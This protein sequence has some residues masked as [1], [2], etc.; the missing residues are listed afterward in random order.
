MLWETGKPINLREI[1]EKVEL[2][3]RSVNMH[4]LGLTKMGYVSKSEEGYYTITD[5]GKE[6]IGFPKVDKDF[7]KKVLSKTPPEKS[8]H[9]YSGIDQPTGISSDSLVDFCEKIKTIDIGPIE[10]HTS[11]GDFE[12][13]VHSLG[14]VELAKRMRLIRKEGLTGEA[15]RERL[16]KVLEARCEEL[17]KKVAN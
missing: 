11:R 7:A 5:S 8:F 9:F 14:D 10:F 4:L 1:S 2:K 12:L 6:A 17:R 16:Y 13:W 15:L 3:V